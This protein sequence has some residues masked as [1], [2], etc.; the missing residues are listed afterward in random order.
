MCKL[1]LLSIVLI[2]KCIW[3]ISEQGVVIIPRGM[4]QE[5]KQEE[6]ES[7]PHHYAIKAKILNMIQFQTRKVEKHLMT[8]IGWAR[9]RGATHHL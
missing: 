7:K 5:S 6:S 2:V 8:K 3:T 4:R 1:G 9:Y